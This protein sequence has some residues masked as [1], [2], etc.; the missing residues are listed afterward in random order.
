MGQTREYADTQLKRGALSQSPI[1]VAMIDSGWSAGAADDRVLP[2]VGFVGAERYL[3]MENRD[4]VDENGHGTACASRILEMAPCINVLPVKVFGAHLDASPEQ[5]RAALR[6]TRSVAVD[7]ICLSLGTF[8]E[9]FAREIYYE[10]QMLA[11]RGVVIVAAAFNRF[12]RGFPAV[13]DNVIGVRCSRFDSPWHFEMSEGSP[14]EC[15]AHGALGNDDV[16]ARCT[17]SIAAATLSGIVAALMTSHGRM[18]RVRTLVAL[19]DLA[20]PPRVPPSSPLELP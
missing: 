3:P 10:C 7:V 15:V 20:C 11:D 12:N 2:G 19:R 18:D 9:H 8:R 1:V 16:G 17:N 5:L 6:W 4:V 13:F 14:V